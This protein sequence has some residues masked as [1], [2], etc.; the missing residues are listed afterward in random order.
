MPT[1]LHILDTSSG[2]T[3]Y[4]IYPKYWDRQAR[5]NSVDPDQMPQNTVSDQG[6]SCLLLIQQFLYISIDSKR[7]LLKF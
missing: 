1:S 3:D 5:A 4:G 2:Q 6:L 7:D